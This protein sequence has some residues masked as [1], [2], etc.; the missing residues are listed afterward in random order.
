MIGKIILVFFI[1]IIAIVSTMVLFNESHE[2]TRKYLEAGC[3][4]LNTDMYGESS[5]WECPKGAIIK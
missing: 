3:R 5:F 1:I 4:P 2:K